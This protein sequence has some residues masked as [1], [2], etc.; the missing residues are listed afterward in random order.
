MP[1]CRDVDGESVFR[2]ALDEGIAYTRGD[3]F[4]VD[5]Q[6]V[7]QASLSFAK[8]APPRI[9]EGIGRLAAIVSRHLRPSDLRRSA[10]RTRGTL[11]QS[12][13]GGLNVARR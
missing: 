1:R 11:E 2:D 5:G 9:S 7:G 8:L 13:R 6:G 3:A 4:Y 12:R 10:R